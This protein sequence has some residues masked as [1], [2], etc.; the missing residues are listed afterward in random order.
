MYSILGSKWYTY[1]VSV[2]LTIS[3][4]LRKLLTIPDT[5]YSEKQET[6]GQ[7][8]SSSCTKMEVFPCWI[9][10]LTMELADITIINQ[11]SQPS[12]KVKA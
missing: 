11:T 12:V 1:Q 8:S 6:V 10:L 4:I 7:V 2:V 9:S 5:R 3:S